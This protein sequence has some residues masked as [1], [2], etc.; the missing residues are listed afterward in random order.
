MSTPVP[1]IL[2]SSIDDIVSRLEALRR[3]KSRVVVAIDGRGG[4]GKSSLARALVA[5]VPHSAHI[6]HDWFH[7]PKD[8]VVDG[9]R[10]DHERL[11]S[12]VIS[13]FR[14]GS[15]TISFLRYNWG[16]LAGLPDG[17]HETPIAIQEAEIL[18][19][20]GCETLH[21]SLVSHLDLR[22]WL[23]AEPNVS[24]ERGIRRD[25]E[26]Y[27][28]DPDRV[29]AAWRE[30]SDWEAQSLA[31][32]DRR[33]RA[34]IVLPGVKNRTNELNIAG[35]QLIQAAVLVTEADWRAAASVM[36]IL[37]PSLREEEFVARREQLLADG[38]VL[39]GLRVND[40]VVSMA[41]YT[42]S[43]HV[44][45]GRELLVHDM[46]TLPNFQ[47]QGYATNLIAEIVSVAEKQAC[48]RVF[49]HTRHA[50]ALYARNGFR[51]YST[52]MVRSIGG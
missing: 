31:R 13:P 29:Y 6:E 45:Y 48:G 14:S 21:A 30:W 23:D 27:K 12:E 15:R 5:A 32:D 8:L 37:R 3:Q 10:F 43:P 42:I 46:A 39:L 11:I 34:D 2:R 22:V 52:G 18:V 40:Q 35:T 44:V 50:Q 4:A 9:H 38:Y 28:L 41:S 17:F 47:G 24:M 33:R 51:E 49:V 7:L 16:Y 26:E 36:Q 20:E 1:K 25:I 19:I